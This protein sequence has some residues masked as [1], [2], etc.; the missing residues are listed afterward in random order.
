[1]APLYSWFLL[2]C[3][4]CDVHRD[5]YGDV[6]RFATQNSKQ[7]KKGA[8]HVY[9]CPYFVDRSFHF[10]LSKNC[11]VAWKEQ[12]AENRRKSRD[13]PNTILNYIKASCLVC[14]ASL[15]IIIF[16]FLFLSFPFI[17]CQLIVSLSLSLSLSAYFFVYIVPFCSLLALSWVKLGATIVCGKISRVHSP[18]GARITV[19][20]V[21][22]FD[23]LDSTASLHTHTSSILSGFLLRR[24][25]GF[26]LWTHHFTLI[27]IENTHR[28]GKDHRMAGL[29]FYKLGFNFFPTYK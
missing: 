28:R 21:S 14:S 7:T 3:N 1:M 9:Q 22:N 26:I 2:L 8:P 16:S 24:H 25:I 5:R 20:L 29:Q 23:S 6:S 13:G 17:T 11:T 12:K 10:Y 27:C 18:V 19:W 15:L 4:T